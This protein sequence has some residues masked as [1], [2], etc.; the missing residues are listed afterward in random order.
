MPVNSGIHYTIFEGRAESHPVVVLIHGAGS[1][2]L[3]WPR[4]LRRLRG[5]R[6][7]TIDLPGHGKTNN[8]NVEQSLHSS[9]MQVIDFLISLSINRVYLVGHS[10]G[11]AIA[12]SI[13][14]RFPTLL[15]GMVLI[16]SGAYFG[17]DK[18]WLTTMSNPDTMG[19]AVEHFRRAAFS[20][21]TNP[22]IIKQVMG[23]MEVTRSSVIYADWLACS[24]FDLREYVVE[25][26]TKT[27]LIWG[28]DD[29]ITPLANAHYLLDQMAD[30][31]L[32][33]IP[34]AGHMVVLEKSA[35]V[36]D[37]IQR[38]ISHLK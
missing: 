36:A 34:D 25:I 14:N 16:S 20:S 3:V 5:N 8:R 2:R 38:F 28:A 13:A 24:E 1:S 18:D 7:L 11:G 12:L 4:E 35:E 22:E 23:E 10:M 29:Q 30:A 19:I 26:K 37:S 33:I 31:D 9:A 17:V 6:V 32:E 15:A 27:K 21:K